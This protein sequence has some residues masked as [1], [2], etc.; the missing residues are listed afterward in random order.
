M[1]PT[2]Y[3]RICF[4][5]ALLLYLCLFFPF[6][7][8]YIYGLLDLSWWCVDYDTGNLRCRK[9]MILVCDFILL[10]VCI[11]MY[12]HISLGPNT[13]SALLSLYTYTHLLHIFI[14]YQGWNSSLGSNFRQVLAHCKWWRKCC[15]LFISYEIWGSLSNED[16]GQVLLHCDAMYC[17]GRMPLFQ[18]YMLPPSEMLVSCHNI[19]WYYNLEELN[20]F[21]T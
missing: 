13:V 5:Q 18:R 8:L 1:F 14:K 19:T 9:E 11:C 17:C 20:L 15:E 2:G 7:V 6:S 21:I 10:T 3:V 12:T 16:S 4:P